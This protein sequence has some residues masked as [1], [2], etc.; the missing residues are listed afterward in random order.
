VSHIGPVSDHPLDDLA[1]YAI[2]ALDPAERHAV[3]DHLAHCSA[4]SAELAGHRETLGALAPGEVPPPEVW[5]RISAVIGAPGLPDPHTGTRGMAVLDDSTSSRPLDEGSEDGDDSVAPVTP[6]AGA[7]RARARRPS[8]RR[9]VA[10]V[11]ALVVAASVGGLL[12]FALG[13]SSDDADIGSLAQQA[14]DD[15]NGV[16]ATLADS[17][18]R[19]V[20]RVVADE[21]GAFMLLD[22]LQD[23]PDG[24]AYQL[25]SV[26]GPEPVSL[27]MLGRDGTNTVAFRLPPTISE[28]AISVAPTSGDSAPSGEFQA[29]GSVLQ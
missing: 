22:A 21:D 10:A 2:D 9:W 7:A 24:R 29:S 15:P 5:Q 23:L 14:L 27:G 11:A 28:L 17:D 19:P 25:W 20:A 12:G 16:L 13:N 3:D 18:G 6:L 8:P 26:G 1:A 4:C